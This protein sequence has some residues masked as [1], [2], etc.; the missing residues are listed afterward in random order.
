[1]GLLDQALIRLRQLSAIGGSDRDGRLRRATLLLLSLITCF[2][3]MLW[4]LSYWVLGLYSVAMIPFAYT[5]IVLFSIIGFI[6][7]ERFDL[8][9]WTQLSLLMISPFLVQW[10]L[11][12]F[13]PAGGVML[14]SILAAI[15]AA[16][17]LG[18]RRGWAFFGAFL[19][20]AV[21]SLLFDHFRRPATLP[22][23]VLVTD[24]GVAA[25]FTA[26]NVVG[27][28]TAIFG[29]IVYA[30]GELRHEQANVERLL[31]NILPVSIA[32]RMRAGETAIADSFEEVTILFA[33]VVGFTRLAAAYPADNIVRLLNRI[34]TAFD[35]VAERW[36]VEK[37]KTIGD[38]YMVASG[39][40]IARQDHAA[41]VAEVALAM[42]DAVERIAAEQGIVLQLRL[43]I[44][45]GPV[46]AGIIGLKKFAYD[47]WGDTVNIASRMEST[48]PAGAIQISVHT[49]KR[50]Q[51]LYALETREPVAIRGRGELETFLLEGRRADQP[52]GAFPVGRDERA[53]SDPKV[54]ELYLLA[55]E[56]R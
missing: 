25:V 8:F 56:R 45:T 10:Q 38:A 19:A 42:R 9:A 39:L 31:R 17:F 27:V 33:D 28:T 16:A 54:V 52:D 40:P 32:E 46:V 55:S 3:G 20:L 15:G 36:D 48:A 12:G 14:W 35:E 47:I 23:E 26:L 43:G 49:A 7:S 41:V 50:L 18:N 1:M 30:L 22:P 53:D 11:G 21:G 5:F 4:G 24:P 29:L 2:A 13:V 51:S 44:H 6:I 37:I 34:F